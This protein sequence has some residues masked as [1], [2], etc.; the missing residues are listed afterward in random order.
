MKLIVGLGNPGKEYRLTRHNMG[1][2]VVEQL[3]KLNNLKFKIRDRFKAY[4][5]EGLIEG[6]RVYL[7]MPQT[8][9]NLSGHSVRSVANWLKIELSDM[10]VVIDDIAFPFGAI[11]I[12]AKGSDAGHNGLRSV[13]DCVGTEEFS[14]IRI[15]ILG[16]KIAR[17]R[18]KYVLSRFTKTEQKALPSIVGRATEACGCWIEQGINA[19][20]NRFN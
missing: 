1:F 15:G 11:K 19:A 18:S 6:E 10:L 12:K 7:A 9:M 2:M 3:A 8:F 14:R 20:M 17:D 13:I 4:T 16:R 5:A